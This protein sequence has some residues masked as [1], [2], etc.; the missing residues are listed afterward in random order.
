MKAFIILSVATKPTI[1]KACVECKK[2]YDGKMQCMN[3]I[4]MNMIMVMV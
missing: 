4:N 1:C 2:K 3:K